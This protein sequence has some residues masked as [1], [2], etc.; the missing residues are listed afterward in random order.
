MIEMELEELLGIEISKWNVLKE[1]SKKE[2]FRVGRVCE[3][4]WIIG[5]GKF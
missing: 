5:G 4:W 3:V 2:I 1:G